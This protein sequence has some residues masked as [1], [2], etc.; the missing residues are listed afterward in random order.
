MG[1]EM[2]YRLQNIYPTIA[3]QSQYNWHYIVSPYHR[4][5][6]LYT[7]GSNYVENSLY[8]K[9]EKWVMK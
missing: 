9:T 5:T 1:D 6:E 8:T 3:I 4:S 7:Y 2:R